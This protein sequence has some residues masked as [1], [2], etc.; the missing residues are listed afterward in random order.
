[1]TFFLVLL[2]LAI[3]FASAGQI[4]L[5]YSTTSN[6]WALPTMPIFNFYFF[7]AALVYLASMLFYTVALKGLPIT[8][9]YPSMALS[10]VIVSGFSNIVW[11]TPFGLLQIVALVLMVIA[12]GLLAFSDSTSFDSSS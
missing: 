4:L 1:M 8:L 9:A 6:T 3:M 11:K 2:F 7:A 5:K 10:Y 12:L